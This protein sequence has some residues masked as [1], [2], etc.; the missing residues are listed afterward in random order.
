MFD[1]MPKEIKKDMLDRLVPFGSKEVPSHAK[2][3]LVGSIFDDV[4]ERYDLMN[5]IMSGGIHRIWKRRIID[6]LSSRPPNR[7]LDLAG[8]T[9][10]IA[11][12]ARKR[13]A[14]NE[15]EITVCDINS[16]MLEQ[17]RKRAWDLGYVRSINWL[18]AN[19]ES[20]P[21]PNNQFDACTLGFG[22]RNMTSIE[23]ALSE[24][25]RVIK[26]GGRFICL[27]FTPDVAPSLNN[28][29]KAYSKHIIP[30]LGNW[31]TGHPEA[32]RY[33]VDSIRRFPHASQVS[34]MLGQAGFGGIRISALSAGIASLHSAWR[35]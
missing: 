6:E 34:N 10:D 18:C 16:K 25:A 4:A 17:G 22:L 15:T 28:A 7:L 2:S 8:G 14:I 21:F 26:P 1:C 13:F 31:I 11:L 20:L 32:Y 12:R 35:I 33:L 29:Y 9:G 24:I 19:G 27:E 5:D 3:K 30:R 23:E